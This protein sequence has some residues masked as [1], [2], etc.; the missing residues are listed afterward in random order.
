MKTKDSNAV[1]R[2]ILDFYSSD[3][4][5][6]TNCVMDIHAYY[7]KN[8]ITELDLDDEVFLEDYE[9]YKNGI[10]KFDKYIKP[11]LTEYK[12]NECPNC[13]EGLIVKI[14]DKYFCEDCHIEI[15]EL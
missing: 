1:E 6:L 11:T 9:D 3:D 8:I 10:T 14:K 7:L 4:E 5:N 12:S 2:I 15:K 13:I